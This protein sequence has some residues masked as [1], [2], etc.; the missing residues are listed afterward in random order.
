MSGVDLL[1]EAESKGLLSK[2]EQTRLNKARKMGLLEPT[3]PDPVILANPAAP[4]V[5][6]LGYDAEPELK[7]DDI[8]N[9][10]SRVNA[11]TTTG[12]PADLRAIAGLKSTT[13]GVANYLKQQPG[14]EEVRVSEGDVFYRP[15]GSSQ[16]IQFDE[17]PVTARD[18]ADMTGGAIETIPPTVAGVATGGNPLAVAGAQALGST[19]RH[20]ISSQIEGDDEISLTGRAL[21]VGLKTGLAGGLQKLSNTAFDTTID[22]LRPNNI[23]AGQVNKALSTPTA[24]AGRIAA[25]HTGMDL[26]PGAISSN[27]MILGAE[28]AT[29]QSYFTAGQVHAHDVKLGEQ[30]I[31]HIEQTINTIDRNAMG[32]EAVGNTVRDT[33]FGTVQK[34]YNTRASQAKIDYGVVRELSGNQKFFEFNNLRTA[35]QDVAG[36]YQG[37][38]GSDSSKVARQAAQMLKELEKGQGA[39]FFRESSNQKNRWIRW[40]ISNAISRKI[41]NWIRRIISNID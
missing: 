20:G 26:T 14:I 38:P 35:L 23:V 17:N 24:Q 29:R 2:S 6:D 27:K 15:N 12:G 8:Y 30:A 21:D 36:Q 16:F 4:A 13:A 3:K 32:P 25:E 7:L 22:R 28:N 10:I 19:L 9:P 40:V 11:D 34:I 1:L 31:K 5:I 33:I 39:K 37:I 41:G 18:F